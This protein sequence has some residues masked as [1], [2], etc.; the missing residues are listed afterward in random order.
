ML[1]DTSFDILKPSRPDVRNYLQ[2]V[3]ELE[4]KQL[5]TSQTRPTSGTLIDHILVR[6]TD[7][8]TTVRLEPCSWTDHDLLI[9]ETPLVRERRRPPE[10]TI[11]STRVLV[12]DALCLDLLMSDRSTVY[13]STDPDHT[14][15][16]WLTVWSPV[17]DTHMPLKTMKL[18]RPPAPWLTDDDDLRT[19]MRERD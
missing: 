12:P 16:A 6:S 19:L 4:M 10:V 14:W 13:N 9:A 11:R 3:N 5:V 2:M 17:I 7:D 15:K 8:A 18:R 1:G